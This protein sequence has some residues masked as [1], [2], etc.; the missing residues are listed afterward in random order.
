MKKL[1]ILMPLM[2]IALF[3]N[4]CAPAYVD[5]VPTYRETPKP[6]RPTVNH[7]WVNDDWRWQR[8]NRT[9]IQRNG[10]WSTPSRGRAYVPGYWQTK[11]RGHRWVSGRWR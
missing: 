5:T 1:I 9:Y 2:G 7:V 8:Q 4:A 11:P 10:Y 6:Q 3:F